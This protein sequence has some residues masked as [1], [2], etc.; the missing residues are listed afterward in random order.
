M[1]E[2]IEIG[3]KILV[4]YTRG[5]TRRHLVVAIRAMVVKVLE[6]IQINIIK[7]NMEVDIHRSLKLANQLTQLIAEVFHNIIR[8]L[9]GPLLLV[10]HVERHRQGSTSC[11]QC[12]QV[13][14][15]ARSCP[16]SSFQ[17]SSSGVETPMV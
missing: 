4:T 10:L 11:Y 6:M 2:E 13:G 9:I 15:F 5:F 12:G 1:S 3:V 17:S 8:L 14:H 16:I 7:V